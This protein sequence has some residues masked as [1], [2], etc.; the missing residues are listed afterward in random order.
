MSLHAIL[1]VN[2]IL[3]VDTYKGGH[4]WMVPN[5]VVN[6]H[7]VICARKPFIIKSDGGV[8][9]L[10][11]DHIVMSGGQPLATYL[12]TVIVTHD[13]IDE[14]EQEFVE[15]GIDF[16]RHLWE[17]IVNQPLPI[18][19][20]AIPDG[21]VVPVGVPLVTIKASNEDLDLAWLESY[22]ETMTQR[23]IWKMT[24]VAS[25]TRAIKKILK[26]GMLETAGHI[27][28]LDYMFHNFG[29]RGAD[30]GEAS[31]KAA[32]AHLQM[33][34]GTDA[35]DA[36]RYIKKIFNTTAPYGSS[37][38]ATEHSI[39]CMNSDADNRNDLNA[40]R[41]CVDWLESEV[42][43][44]G[45]FAM[46]ASVGDTYDMIRYARDYIGGDELRTRIEE[47]GGR[48]V[49]RPDSGCPIMMPCDVVEV[50][51]EKFGY[52][53]NELGY[54]VLPNCIRV[55]QGDGISIE[56]FPQLMEEIRK[57]EL[58]LENFAFG[59]GGGLTHEHGRDTFSFCQKATAMK[60]VDTWIDLFKD[61]ITD[62]GKR[63][64]R[65]LVTTYCDTFNNTYFTE[66]EN[67]TFSHL[68]HL[69]KY[70]ILE[71]MKVIFVD[72]VLC[73]QQSF[74][75]VRALCFNV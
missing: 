17:Q 58:S 72:G 70:P 55:I 27:E 73:N 48:L 50:L 23:Y 44:L 19:V 66:L 35:V 40:A 46:V 32:I 14:A 3:D 64:H 68:P 49:L 65:G 62:Q 28:G 9:L 43:R 25:I 54:K 42:E 31:L 59:C 4:W 26:E 56:Y 39:T 2:F 22:I 37:I 11:I 61:P 18:E 13:M 51:M 15:Q 60:V 45:G 67:V 38:N 36:N 7:S 8:E 71:A 20:K 29:S 75:D 41:R 1:P 47:S 57:R 16:P 10:E 21:T 33:F 52:T 12:N 53:T 74:D 6:V 5:N 69:D 63:S 34:N 24:T 30:S